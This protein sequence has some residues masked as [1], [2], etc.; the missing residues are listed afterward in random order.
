MFI[1][2]GVFISWRSKEQ[3]ADAQ[4]TVKSEH[5]S[6]SYSI[7]ESFWLMKFESVLSIYT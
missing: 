1:L 3:S 5:F 2:A 6:L 7:R 4:S